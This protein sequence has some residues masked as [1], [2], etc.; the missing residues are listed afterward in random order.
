MFTPGNIG[1]RLDHGT[2]IEM[3]T[4]YYH[5]PPKT[6]QKFSRILNLGTLDKRLDHRVLREKDTKNTN[7]YLH[8][9]YY[10]QPPYSVLLVFALRCIR[11][12]DHGIFT[13]METQIPTIYLQKGTISFDNIHIRMH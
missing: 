12:H 8:A 9:E 5:L 11:Q 1:Q 13:K 6:K 7:I 3:N 4:E 10:H 2:L